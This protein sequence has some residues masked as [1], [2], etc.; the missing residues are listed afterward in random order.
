MKKLTGL[1]ISLSVSALVLAQQK[2]K[3]VAKPAAAKATGGAAMTTSVDS[4]SYALGLSLAQFYKQQGIQRINTSLITKAI[5]DVMKDGKP[6]LTD[7]QMNMCITNYLQ[8]VKTEKA[9]VAKKAGEA[10]LANNKKN[11]GVVTLP[12]GLQYQVITQGTGPK[13]AV[14]DTVRCHYR[15]TLIDGTVFDSSVDRGQPAE[16]P[17]GGVIRGWVEAL[18]LMNVGSK[19]KLFIP[20]DLAYGDNQAGPTI[21]PGS[22]LIFEVELL[23]IVNGGAPKQ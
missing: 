5:N 21:A 22:T 14:T 13:P 4:V 23:A 11:A 6:Q 8:K 9:S 7:E 2:P 12:S 18:P 1:L 19:W 16:F 10:F 15:G 3:A 20:S 17:V